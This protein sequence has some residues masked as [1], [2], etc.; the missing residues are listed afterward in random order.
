MAKAKKGKIKKA[1]QSTQLPLDDMRWRP[2]AQIIEQ[3]L[4]HIGKKTLIAQD[5]TKTLASGKIRCMRR[6]TNEHTLKF[7][8]LSDAELH[9]ITTGKAAAEMGDDQAA[10]HPQLLPASFWDEYYFACSPNGDIR[11]AFG[12]PPNADGPSEPSFIFTA[13]WA[14]YLW[15][16]DCVKAWPALAPQ[17]VAAGEA[18]E[19][20]PLGRKPGPQAEWQ[21]FVAFKYCEMRHKDRPL[22]SASDLQQLCKDELGHKPDRS[23]INRLL[24]GLVRLLG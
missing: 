20:E 24:R 1:K 16:P 21:W 18:T 3:L 14:F 9:A 13:N 5:L 4:P 11:V 8:S 12:L 17:A 15:E 19:S 10:G 7:D 22:P 6:Y 23:A 2:D